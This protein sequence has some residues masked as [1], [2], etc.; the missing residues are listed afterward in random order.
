MRLLQELLEFG[1]PHIV[2]LELNGLNARDYFVAMLQ[3][4]PRKRDVDRGAAGGEEPNPRLAVVRK[5]RETGLLR[6]GSVAHL[7]VRDIMGCDDS[8]QATTED[9]TARIERVLPLLFLTSPH[10]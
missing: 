1:S 10:L 8:L 4:L 7:R 3:Q 9:A 2:P 5:L 6:A